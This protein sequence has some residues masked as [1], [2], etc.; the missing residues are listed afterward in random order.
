MMTEQ[1]AEIRARLKQIR[2]AISAEDRQIF[3]QSITGKILDLEEIRRS[4][5]IFTYISCDGEV[6]THDLINELLKLGKRIAVP[7]I[8]HSDHMEAVAFNDWDELETGQLGILTP[9]S[10]EPAAGNFDVVITPGLGFTTEGF[11]IGY[12]RGYYDKWFATHQ[13]QQKIAVTFDAQILESLPVTEF[14]VPVNMIVTESRII[15]VRI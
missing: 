15:E 4:Q 9:K 1:K 5:H 7:K 3:S 6:G 8:I 14:D 2:S 13:V 12:G 10:C 11:R